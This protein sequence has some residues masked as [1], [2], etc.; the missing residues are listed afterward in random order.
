[1]QA[2]GP[3][4]GRAPTRHAP[5]HPSD[6]RPLFNGKDLA[7]WKVDSG[8]PAV[9]RAENGE[10]VFHITDEKRQL[11]WLLTDRDYS[12]FILRLEFQLAAGGNSAVAIHMPPKAEKQL[13]ANIADDTAPRF[14][15]DPENYRTGSLVGIR[16]DH[17]ADLKPIGQWNAMEITV[18][19]R[20]VQIAVNGK[21]TTYVPFDDPAVAK[22]LGHVAALSGRIGLQACMGTVR[23]RNVE[24]KELQP[25]TVPAPPIA[26][27]SP[28]PSTTPM[29]PTVVPPPMVVYQPTEFCRC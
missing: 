5:S 4:T 10:T 2:A 15:K 25:S 1:M 14:A 13:A 22:H 7:G 23:F 26:T 18:R 29:P 8:D 19:N 3:A 16:L 9:S 21:E 20:S 11:G 12:D 28:T 17:R 6:F 27:S 24:V